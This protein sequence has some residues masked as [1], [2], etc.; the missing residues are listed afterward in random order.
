MAALQSN[1]TG[2]WLRL[3]ARADYGRQTV[4]NI[5]VVVPH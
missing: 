5:F 4:G 1:M 2:L 3:S